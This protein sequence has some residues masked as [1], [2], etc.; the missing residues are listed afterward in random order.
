M[1]Y[2]IINYDYCSDIDISLL[3]ALNMCLL[4]AAFY[5]VPM[6][7]KLLSLINFELIL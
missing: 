4:P 6:Q 3:L 7:S 2:K 1:S 5:Q